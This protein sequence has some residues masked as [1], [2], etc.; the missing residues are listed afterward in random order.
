VRSGELVDGVLT[1]GRLEVT[2]HREVADLRPG[3]WLYVR[4][5][6]EDEGTG[7]TSPIFIED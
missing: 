4:A 3:Q 5:V 6:Q 2:L 1:E 7:W